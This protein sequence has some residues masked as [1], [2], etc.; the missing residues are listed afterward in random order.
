MEYLYHLYKEESYRDYIDNDPPFSL[1]V[2]G[3]KKFPISESLSRFSELGSR[4][5]VNYFSDIKALFTQKNKSASSGDVLGIFKSN[6][7]SKHLQLKCSCLIF[8]LDWDEVGETSLDEVWLSNICNQLR[9]YMNY[10]RSKVIIALVT[11]KEVNMNANSMVQIEKLQYDV[12]V[13]LGSEFK[14]VLPLFEGGMEVNSGERLFRMAFELSTKYHK[15]EVSRIKNGKLDRSYI[16][17]RRKFKIAWHYLVLKDVKTAKRYFED[18]YRTLRD[19]SVFCPM[20]ESRICASILIYH[21]IRAAS[22]ESAISFDD[23]YYRLCENH[24]LWLGQAIRSTCSENKP[25]ARFLKLLLVGECYDWITRYSVNLTNNLQRD[26]TISSLGAF[27]DALNMNCSSS[28][29]TDMVS[30]PFFLGSECSLESHGCIFYSA[31]STEILSGRV[32]EILNRIGTLEKPSLEAFFLSARASIWLRKVEEV[33][34]FLNRV[35]NFTLGTYQECEVFH[36]LLM[37]AYRSLDGKLDESNRDEIMFS[38]VSLSFGPGEGHIQKRYLRTF[39]EMTKTNSCSEIKLCY[40]KKGHYAPFT[41][42]CSFT[43]YYHDCSSR[44]KLNL[45]IFTASVESIIMDSLYVAISKFCSD[46]S[47]SSNTI[48]L[49]KENFEVS[50]KTSRSFL[51]ELHLDE[52]GYYHCSSVKGRV[53]CN[54]VFLNVEWGLDNSVVRQ[55]FPRELEIVGEVSGPSKHRPWIYVVKPVCR[56]ELDV[57]NNITAVEGEEVNVNIFIR[58]EKK[59]E[60]N[61]ILVFPYIPNFYELAGDIKLEKRSMFRDG[62]TDYPA[63]VLD[64]FPVISQGN[65]LRLSVVYKCLRAGKYIVPIFFNYKSVNYSDREIIKR[66]QVNVFYPFS[67]T[68]TLFRV[69]P[70]MVTPIKMDV[71]LGSEISL[72]IPESSSKFV[73]HEVSTLLPP[74]DGISEIATIPQNSKS[75]MLYNGVKEKGEKTLD[76]IFSK[77]EEISIVISMTCQA[78]RGLK[79]LSLDVVTAYDA[80]LI[81]QAVGQLPCSVE[82]LDILTITARIRVLRLGKYSLGFIR[83]LLASEDGTQHIM[84]DFS[85]PEV[86]VESTPFSLTLKSPSVAFLGSPFLLSFDIVN[87]T[88]SSQSCELIIEKNEAFF[89][90]GG[91]TQW[92]FSLGP[93]SVKSTEIILQPLRVGSLK[94]PSAFVRHLSSAGSSLTFACQSD[95]QRVCVLPS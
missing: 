25:V 79:I 39:L 3:K 67:P 51:V 10:S 21:I 29:L 32:Q 54:G 77:G 18:S 75:I 42:L 36:G 30:V 19:I 49:S 76:T 73:Q 56:V 87:K 92:S 12:K 16:T 15:D 41:C 66:I 13:F 95:S 72:S 88:E 71:V 47:K 40:P 20:M 7:C 27:E 69:L 28:H 78:L 85:L 52:P 55:K 26:L 91:R 68:F 46:G 1:A 11:E 24:I 65:P 60:G 9:E 53:S 23:P 37:E 38:F 45:E 70:W 44:T 86:G 83:M 17:V 4:F 63:F 80:L 94:L 84:S 61:G 81:S 62:Q 6:W 2:V 50:L 74:R 57:P 31:H 5:R 90:M 43:E 33:F 8:C 14:Y 82:Y 58:T 59:L 93:N 64:K 35:R 22:T 48:L 34:Y 89:V